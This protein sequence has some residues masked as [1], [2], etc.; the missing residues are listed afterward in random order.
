MERK[1][2]S[3][4]KDL[5]EKQESEKIMEQVTSLL[6]RHEDLLFKLGLSDIDSIQ[7]A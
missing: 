6:I 7:H 3:F 1:I 4:L 2:E 5:R